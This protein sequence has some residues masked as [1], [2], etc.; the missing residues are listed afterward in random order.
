MLDHLALN[1]L[2]GTAKLLDPSFN[3]LSI[4]YPYANTLI[5][6]NP[7]GGPVV[8]STLHSL[9]CSRNGRIDRDKILQLHQDSALISRQSKLRVPWDIIKAKEGRACSCNFF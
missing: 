6:K 7:S 9:I 2:E 3:V 8:S 4:M 1:T 5:L